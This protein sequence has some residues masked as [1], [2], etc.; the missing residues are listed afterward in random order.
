MCVVCVGGGRTVYVTSVFSFE[1]QKIYYNQADVRPL[2]KAAK[3]SCF[4]HSIISL[5]L[6]RSFDCHTS[7]YLSCCFS[8]RIKRT[9]K[10]FYTHFSAWSRKIK[11]RSKN[12]RLQEKWEELYFFVEMKMIFCTWTT[13]FLFLIEAQ[14]ALKPSIL[15]Y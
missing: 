6:M 11:K 10:Y 8:C 15:F 3:S 4:C 14:H 2:P 12:H 7:P 5:H 9:V 1:N 13:S